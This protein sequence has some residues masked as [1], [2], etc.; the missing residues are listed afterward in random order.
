MYSKWGGRMYISKQQRAF[1]S[2][3]SRVTLRNNSLGILYKRT[4]KGTE[5]RTEVR[6]DYIRKDIQQVFSDVD[7]FNTVHNLF[8][9]SMDFF[10]SASG[11]ISVDDVFSSCFSKKLYIQ[12][13]GGVTTVFDG[14]EQEEITWKG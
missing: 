8:P 3:L 10:E 7:L 6:I 2:V 13:F 4:N 11:D 5:V 14:D 1:L 9:D 12:S